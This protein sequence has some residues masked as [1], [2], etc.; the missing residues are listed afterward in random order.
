MSKQDH[1]MFLYVGTMFLYVELH[2]MFWD[3]AVLEK[4]P[5]RVDFVN[6]HRNEFT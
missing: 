4:K 3:D 5:F 2:G 1:Q 6:H